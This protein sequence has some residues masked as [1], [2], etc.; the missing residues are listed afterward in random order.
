MSGTGQP[1]AEA[2]TIIARRSRTRSLAVRLICCSRCPSAIDNGRTNTSGGRAIAVPP[3]PN[4]TSE[5]RRGTT[6]STTSCRTNVH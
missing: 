5:T 1:C 4:T 2:N 6:D 3:D